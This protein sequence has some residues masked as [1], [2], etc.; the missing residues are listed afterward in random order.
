MRFFINLNRP[1][2]TFQT[3]CFCL[4]YLSEKTF[5]FDTFQ[6]VF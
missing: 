4:N 6:I 1:S 5:S 3:A 2:E